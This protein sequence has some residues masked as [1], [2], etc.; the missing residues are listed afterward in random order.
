MHVNVITDCVRPVRCRIGLLHDGS[1][2]FVLV[3]MRLRFC[4]AQVGRPFLNIRLTSG[5]YPFH[6]PSMDS[7]GVIRRSWSQSSNGSAHTEAMAN[8]RALRCCHQ[9][10]TPC[11]RYLMASRNLA[12]GTKPCW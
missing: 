7:P 9:Q 11:Q 8:V 6:I 10:T 3:G 2:H 4:N 12:I 1:K 5:G